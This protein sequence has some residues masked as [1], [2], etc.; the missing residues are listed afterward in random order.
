MPAL[1]TQG[2]PAFSRDTPVEG[3]GFPG[4]VLDV[5]SSNCLLLLI[6]LLKSKFPHPPDLIRK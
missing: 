1:S 3:F 5:F 2:P 4:A 6:Y